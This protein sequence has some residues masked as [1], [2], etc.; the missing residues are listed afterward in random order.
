MRQAKRSE[1]INKGEIILKRCDCL[2]VYFLLIVNSAVP[3]KLKL[4]HLETS[5]CAVDAVDAFSVVNMP[6]LPSGG[7]WRW[8]KQGYQI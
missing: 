4:S 1:I 3:I 6:L 2:V 7:R 8:E 5:F